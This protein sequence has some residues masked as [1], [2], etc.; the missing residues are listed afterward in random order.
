M[1][2][3][4]LLS[5]A[6]GALL[7]DV[8]LHLIPHGTAHYNEMYNK[9][10]MEEGSNEGHHGHSHGGGEKECGLRIL[11]GFAVFF[12]LQKIFDETSR[13]KGGHSHKHLHDRDKMEEKKGADGKVSTGVLFELEQANTIFSLRREP[14]LSFLEMKCFSLDSLEYAHLTEEW[15]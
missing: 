1:F 12:M 9:A 4:A 15:L 6:A 14:P 2:L 7:G 8:F 13:G 11:G 10:T 5:L 3:L